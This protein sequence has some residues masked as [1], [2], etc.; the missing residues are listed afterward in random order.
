VGGPEA[1]A[2]RGGS[3]S[4]GQAL[5]EPRERQLVAFLQDEFPVEPGV[6]WELR[7][8]G[9]M[10]FREADVMSAPWRD[11]STTRPLS[12]RPSCALKP[13]HFCSPALPAGRSGLSTAAVSMGAGRVHVMHGPFHARRVG[14][15]SQISNRMGSHRTRWNTG[16]HSARDFL[17]GRSVCL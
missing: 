5:L 6:W 3:S 17:R 8:R 4:A 16:L 13:S 14:D 12:Q 9:L 15:Q 11:R 10:N 1:D 7:E 2:L